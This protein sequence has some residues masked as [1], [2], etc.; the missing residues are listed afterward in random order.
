[1]NGYK[2]GSLFKIIKVVIQNIN[3][4]INAQT[5]SLNDLPYFDCI[6]D[7]KS[8]NGFSWTTQKKMQ[9]KISNLGKMVCNCTLNKKENFRIQCTFINHLYFQKDKINTGIG[10]GL[11]TL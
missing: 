7:F 1:M 9:K 8:L 4:I 11:S 5:T 2:A 6:K 10:M 3:T